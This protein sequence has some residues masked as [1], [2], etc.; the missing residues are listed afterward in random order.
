MCSCSALS[1]LTTTIVGVVLAQSFQHNRALDLDQY[2]NVFPL[3]EA[4]PVAVAGWSAVFADAHD[5]SAG[6]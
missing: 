5:D 2:V 6:A 1:L 3:L 4:Q